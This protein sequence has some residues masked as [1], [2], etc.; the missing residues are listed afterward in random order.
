MNVEKLQEKVYERSEKPRIP[1]KTHRVWVTDSINPTEMVDSINEPK[2]YK[3]LLK[4]NKA[5]NSP[6][7]EWTHYFW[8]NDKKAIPRTVS[9]FEENGVIVKEIHELPS[10]DEIIAKSMD[11]YTE[12][13]FGAAA[14]IIR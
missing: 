6:G 2:I 11:E 5:L 1:L 14:D 7:Y 9:W 4:T 10:Y 12:F 13:R 8:T 3:E